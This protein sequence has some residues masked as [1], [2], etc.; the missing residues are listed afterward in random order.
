MSPLY[1]APRWLRAYRYPGARR[2]PLLRRR[3]RHMVILLPR[4]LLLHAA[5]I[6]NDLD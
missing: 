4:D 6:T 5:S 1:A 3:C 2:W